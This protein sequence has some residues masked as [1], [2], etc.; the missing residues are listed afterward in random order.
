LS[1]TVIS[2]ERLSKR[3]FVGHNAAR[4]KG[5]TAL[6]DVLTRNARNLARKTR[7]MISGRPIIQG[8]EIEEFWALKDVSFAIEKRRPCRHY[9]P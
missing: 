4:A 7:D 8:D 1:D 6:R 9:W 5:Y 2:V 3:Y